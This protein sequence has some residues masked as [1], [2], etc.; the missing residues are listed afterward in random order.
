MIE[1]YI[2]RAILMK[3]LDIGFCCA[4]TDPHQLLNEIK[5]TYDIGL[6]FLDVDLKMEINGFQLANEIRKYDPRGFI[7]F[8]TT[9]SEMSYLTFKYGVEA[10]DYI[11]KDFPD[12]IEDSIHKVIVTAYE[13]Y[14]RLKSEHVRTLSIKTDGRI[15]YID[16]EAILYIE[17][18]QIPHKLDMHLK[19]EIIG[20]YGCLRD[21]SNELGD[22]FFRCH[23]SFVIHLDSVRELKREE[24]MVVMENGDICPVSVQFYKKL[25][26]RLEKM[27]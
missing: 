15:M 26:D 27:N 22:R 6:Y 20:F 18:S 25:L 4:S 3:G 13:R 19:D 16:E 9:H 23:K 1:E 10:M 11:I 24:R 21:W 8:I 7:V 17:S 14:E 5:K 12:E 2:T